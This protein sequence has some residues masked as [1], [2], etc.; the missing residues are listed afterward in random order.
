M[1]RV[2]FHVN[3]TQ[4]WQQRRCAVESLHGWA[5]VQHIPEHAAQAT[6][7]AGQLPFLREATTM[8]DGKFRELLADAAGIRRSHKGNSQAFPG[9]KPRGTEKVFRDSFLAREGD[10]TKTTSVAF[11]AP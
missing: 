7:F 8:P 1:P 11:P 3:H 9:G 10:C 5:A 4:R 2:D 6:L